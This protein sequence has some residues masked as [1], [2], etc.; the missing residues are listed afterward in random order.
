MEGLPGSYGSLAMLVRA[1]TSEVDLE[2]LADDE[3]LMATGALEA[4]GRL[5]DAARVAHAAEIA[6]RS[7]ADLGSVRLSARKGCANAN[8]LLQRVTRVAASTAERRIRLGAETRQNR[9]IVGAEFPARFDG[10]ARA[11]GRGDIGVDAA[12]AIVTSLTPTTPRASIAGLRAAESELVSAAHSATAADIRAQ[13]LIWQVVLD[14]DGIEPNE[15]RAMAR[16]G[17]RLGR[18][19]SGLVPISGALMPEIAAK[20]TTAI[21]SRLN[22]RTAPIFLTDDDRESSA[23][24]GD[25]RSRDQQRHDIFASLIDAAARSGELPT[26]GGAAPTVLVSV[27]EV[28]LSADAGA[29]AIDGLDTPISLRSVRQ[30]ACAGGIQKVSISRA[31]RILSLGSPERCFTPQLRRAIALRDGGCVMPGCGVPAAWSEIHHVTPDSRGGPTE[32]ENGVMLC[33]FHHRTI[34]SA[35]WHISMIG[36]VPHI[37]APPWIDRN[38]EWRPTTKSRTTLVGALVDAL[39]SG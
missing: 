26:A 23:I 14:P 11:L 31:G 5:I 34:D 7:R 30:F 17:L 19:R 36:G 20:L 8:E 33:W 9:S 12:W 10:V 35:G 25:V 6:H 32:T 28:D 39:G 21:D 3:L 37:K 38:A 16:R 22:P 15:D 24:E 27:R 13:A 1:A 29:G 2:R 18:E 4:V